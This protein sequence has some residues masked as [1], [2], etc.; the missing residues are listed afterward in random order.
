MAGASRSAL[1]HNGPHLK[2]IE[3]IEFW[4]SFRVGHRGRA[5]ELTASILSGVA[6]LWCAGKQDGY[7]PVG[8]E[9]RRFIGLWP[10]AGMLIC[11]AWIGAS[12]HRAGTDLLF[13]DSWS[14][15]DNEGHDTMV[16]AQETT[17]VEM[18]A[19]A[20]RL[21]GILADRVWPRFGVA[22]KA[23]RVVVTP[24]S[25][26]NYRAA[27]LWFSWSQEAEAPDA[28]TLASLVGRLVGC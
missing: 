21:D 14:A 16:F 19:L 28:A 24:E 15:E 3:P 2:G 26:G 18:S 9:A 10:G 11:D 17:R 4:K 22:Q 13:P 6:P 23:H 7:G 20:G 5:V 8:V 1:A 12:Q 27:A 25:Y